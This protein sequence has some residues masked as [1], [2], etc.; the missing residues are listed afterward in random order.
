M[1][2][3]MFPMDT[4]TVMKEYTEKS[5]DFPKNPV[6]FKGNKPFP[7]PVSTR[8]DAKNNVA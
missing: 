7:I 1:D 6:N 3:L 2:K 5:Y 8:V 4:R